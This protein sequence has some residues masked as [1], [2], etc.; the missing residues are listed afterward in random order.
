M[1]E[2]AEKDDV[3]DGDGR[4]PASTRLDA[5][6]G[7]PEPAAAAHPPPDVL[8]A[9][10]ERTLPPDEA[11]RLR[12]HLAFCDE[13]HQT[14]LDLATFPEIEAR[15]PDPTE[16]LDLGRELERVRQRARG[17]HDGSTGPSNEKG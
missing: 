6:D 9:Y 5:I 4:D 13:C 10:V 1:S 3:T 15:A 17:P 14:V 16:A 8:L 7:A 12:D 2:R 11:E